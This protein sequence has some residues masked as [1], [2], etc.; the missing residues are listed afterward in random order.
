MKPKDAMPLLDINIFHIITNTSVLIC[1]LKAK[2]W[3]FDGWP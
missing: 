3:P 1:E 2:L